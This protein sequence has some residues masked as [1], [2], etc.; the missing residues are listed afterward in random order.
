M[1]IAGLKLCSGF[2]ACLAA[3]LLPGAISPAPSRLVGLLPAATHAAAGA[4]DSLSAGSDRPSRKGKG[5]GGPE[6]P[7]TIPVT[8]QPREAKAQREMTIANLLIREDGDVQ[9][10]LSYRTQFD[11]PVSLS[12]LVQDDLNSSVG[13]E[14]KGIAH[15]IRQLPNGSRVFVGY[16]RSGSLEVR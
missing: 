9:T 3:G 4:P 2:F 6:K 8:I 11:T 15:F 7:I 10:G 12:V 14:I 5:H 1:S 13:S 16:I